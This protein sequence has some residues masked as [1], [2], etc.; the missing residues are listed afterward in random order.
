M[1][2]R[3]GRWTGRLAGFAAGACIAIQFVPY[4]HDRA[5]PPVVANRPAASRR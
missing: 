5:T 1:L 4:G 3:I 2:S